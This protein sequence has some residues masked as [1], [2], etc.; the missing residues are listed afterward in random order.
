VT[1]TAGLSVLAACSSSGGSGSAATPQAT[2][3]ATVAASGTPAASAAAKAKLDAP[4]TV[5]MLT[6]DANLKNEQLPIFK[7]LKDATN[8]TIKPT[9]PAGTYKDALAVAMASGELPDIV[10]IDGEALAIKYGE[11]G[12]LLDL[13][14]HLDKMPNLKAFWERNP[15]LKKRGTG[16]TGETYF[17]VHDGA[18][19]GNQHAWMYRDEVFKAQ[20]ITPPKTWDELYAALKKLKAAYPDSYPLTTR[21]GLGKVKSM[22][23]MFGSAPDV[24]RDASGTVK[25]GPVEDGFKKLIEYYNTFYKEKLVNTDFLSATVQ[26]W[27]EMMTTNKG[28]V[29][30]DYVGR[31]E[32]L[33][34]AIPGGTG[35]KR[36]FTIMAPPAG[37]N[38]KSLLVNGDYMLGGF[39]VFSKSKNLDATLHLID[40]LYS[41]AGK[42]LVSWGVE[43]Q[44]YQ[45]AG[46]KKKMN[47]AN[48]QENKTTYGIMTFGSYGRFD[49][50]AG[51][52]LTADIYKPDYEEALKYKTPEIVLPPAF[53]GGEQEIIST[54]YQQIL[55]DVDAN[56][57][58]F[59]MGDRPLSEWNQ[60]VAEIQKLGLQKVLDVYK[61]AWDRQSKK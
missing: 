17:A 50:E 36:S 46:G 13:G 39:T 29:T 19:Y 32:L 52:S 45:V 12:A 10:Y 49:K 4:A 16:A 59:I 27:Q 56:L 21:D 57:A 6:K 7:W 37:P 31:A 43:G 11:Q 48:T 40:Y 3:A 51:L 5:G 38:G 15:E 20:S 60:Y 30:L 61:A 23:S 2:A 1:I 58:K 53:T 34:A 18:G 44:S 54:T 55:K 42:E 33:D 35:G 25:F 47:G 24:Y 8:I 9:V 26:Q 28:F 41:D 22:A 14:K